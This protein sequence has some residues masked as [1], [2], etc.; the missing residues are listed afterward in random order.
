MLA[1]AQTLLGDSISSLD[2]L[3]LASSF[4]RIAGTS[5][6]LGSVISNILIDIGKDFFAAHHAN[7]SPVEC[8]RTVDEASRLHRRFELLPFLSSAFV[9]ATGRSR[10]ADAG[11]LPGR[12]RISVVA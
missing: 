1:P 7:Y 9:R 8:D 2:L 6:I 11:T 4:A 5:K 10:H 12:S 3:S